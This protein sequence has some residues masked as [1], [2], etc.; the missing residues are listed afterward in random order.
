[1][2]GKG[3]STIYLRQLTYYGSFSK[4]GNTILPYESSVV[5]IYIV[6]H[7]DHCVAQVVDISYGYKYAVM[8]FDYMLRPA[9]GC[10]DNRFATGKRL[11][12]DYPKG[13]VVTRMYI[14]VTLTHF[15]KNLLVP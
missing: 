9:T 8:L 7:R 5:V 4:S 15:I 11:N 6:A 1:M 3:N 10:G 13:F 12:Y 14:Y 2:A